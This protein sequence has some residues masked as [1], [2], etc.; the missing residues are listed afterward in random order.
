MG[1]GPVD[2]ATIIDAGAATR[3]LLVGSLPPAGRDYDVLASESD[4]S[5]IEAALRAGGFERVQG[6]WVRFGPGEPDVVDL[7][8]PSE[9]GLSD[10]AAEELFA[11][12]VPL[13]GRDRLCVPAPTHQLLIA[14]RKLPRTP[15]LLKPGQRR[16]VADALARS[17][18][19]FD[20]ARARAGEWGVE[21]RL[22]RLQARFARPHRARWPPRWFR[23][24]KRGAVIAL[25]GLD[26]V[27][28]STQARALAASLTKLGY[29][30]VV[31]WSPVG[32]NASLLRFAAAVKRA[33]ALLPVG[34]LAH[35][36]R[37]AV[38]RHLLSHKDD[39][40]GA[41]RPPTL[42]AL[43]W[44]T[45]ITFENALSYRRLARGTRVGRRVVIY[46]RYVLDTIVDL[47][48]SYAPDGRLPLQEALLRLLS[49]APRC[50]FL[51]D[52]SPDVAHGR[53]PDWSLAQT[54]VRARLYRTE[55]TQLGLRRID[56][57]RPADELGLQII[58]E[59]LEVLAP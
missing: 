59:V 6:D 22:R 9:W 38:E 13:D 18:E 11:Q 40:P 4:R 54:R 44:A 48:F 45:L 2:V 53:K 26:G 12:A 55:Y 33:L 30:A 46:D 52:A 58:R 25:S 23:R 56:A 19:A 57:E 29:E 41:A 28:K 39:P 15:G 5:L 37:A 35:G 51:L 20:Q 47:R 24:P 43:V 10:R 3:V 36:D 49:P 42:A 7:L 17:P 34:P 31:V 50:A 27:G 1:H 8:T 21:R 32:H 14:A 16:R